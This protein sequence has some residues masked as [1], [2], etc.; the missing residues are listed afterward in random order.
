[1]SLKLS[2]ASCFCRDAYD[3]EPKVE[4]RS[5][6]GCWPETRR[7]R[8]VSFH[9]REIKDYYIITWVSGA[10]ERVESSKRRIIFKNRALYRTRMY[11]CQ[12]VQSGQPSFML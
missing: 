4:G 12:G 3:P 6:I 2:P 5:T 11:M 1:M 10:G 7:R 9:I 8:K